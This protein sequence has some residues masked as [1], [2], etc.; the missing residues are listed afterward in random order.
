[1]HKIRNDENGMTEISKQPSRSL[2]ERLQAE[3]AFHDVKYAGDELYP[4]HYAVRPT[5]YIYQQMRTMLG[6]LRG[7]E[8]LEYGCGEGWNTSDLARLGARVSAFDVSPQA[9]ENTRQLL[10]KQNLLG[11]CSLAVMP[12]EKLAYPDESFDVAVGFAIIHHL[13]LPT[14]FRELHR[15]LRPGG[16]AWFAEPLGT[17][18]A[19]QLYRRFTPQ[20]R[21]VDER[22]LVL[23]ELPVLLKDYSSVEHREFYLT[24]LAAIGVSYLPGGARIFPAISRPLHKLDRGLLRIIP[25][26]GKWAWYTVLKITK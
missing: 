12:A 22:P 24:A 14:A 10:E 8:V 15:V 4:K 16:V 6:D 2:E 26:L 25:G 20:F 7:K 13:D 11:Q 19:I 5:E 1:V 18:P 23:E 17:N 21:T 3:A 9:I